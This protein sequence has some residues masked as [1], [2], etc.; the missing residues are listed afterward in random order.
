MWLD[1]RISLFLGGGGEDCPW[2]NIC[3]QSSSF[4]LRKIIPELTSVP[5][6]LYFFYVGCCHSMAWWAACGCASG[7]QTCEPR[8]AKAEYTKP[9]NA[10]GPA[11]LSSP[12]CTF[13]HHHYEGDIQNTLCLF[14]TL[15]HFFCF[16]GL[17]L[18]ASHDS[19]VASV[20]LT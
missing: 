9:N 10:I 14:T 19:W 12:F 6:F 13:I 15:L 17:E 7:I 5:I 18:L 1:L 4:C 2:A 3:C 11:P 8:A 16:D 20:I